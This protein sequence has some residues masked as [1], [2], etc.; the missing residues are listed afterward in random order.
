MAS[1]PNTLGIL[2]TNE[3][4]NSDESVSCTPVIAAVMRDLKKYMK[5]KNEATGQR[6]L[7]TGYGAATIQPRDKAI[8]DHLSLGD[9]T[10]RIDFW[11]AS[12]CTFPDPYLGSEGN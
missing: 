2:A 5:L 10:N 4:M 3:L 1:F 7:P 9:K 6:I 11:T 12:A 8:L